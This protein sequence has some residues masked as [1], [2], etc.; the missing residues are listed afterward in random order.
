MSNTI[1]ARTVAHVSLNDSAEQATIIPVVLTQDQIVSRS[2]LLTGTFDETHA[3]AGQWFADLAVTFA[4]TATAGARTRLVATMPKVL[5]EGILGGKGEAIGYQV[6]TVGTYLL[7][8]NGDETITLDALQAARKAIKDATGG[9]GG[10]A[11]SRAEC[12]R[13]VRESASLADIPASIAAEM[14]LR[15][16]EKVERPTVTEDAAEVDQAPVQD[17]LPATPQ[18]LINNAAA[19]L[20]AETL[21]DCEDVLALDVLAQ[22]VT[23]LIKQNKINKAIT[24]AA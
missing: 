1:T 3:A 7:R 19:I 9:K 21:R 10:T 13:I 18:E 12:A 20:N 15:K 8:N 22:L 11:M 6:A 2:N 4:S 16:T 17:Q 24:V 14:K 23:K 5:A